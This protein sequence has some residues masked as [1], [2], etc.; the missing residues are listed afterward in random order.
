M[1]AAPRTYPPPPPPPYPPPTPPRASSA[2]SPSRLPGVSAQQVVLGTAVVTVL[3]F[4][5]AAAQ[6]GAWVGLAVAALFA[7]AGGACA[8]LVARSGAATTAEALAVTSVLTTAAGIGLW[9]RGEPTPAPLVAAL[10]ATAALLWTA[11]QVAPDR[12]RTWPVAALVAGQVAVLSWL[13]TDPRPWDTPVSGAVLAVV[14][15]AVAGVGL[16]VAWTADGAGHGLLSRVGLL[17]AVPW[18][19]T[20]VVVAQQAAW[21]G[22]VP[23]AGATVLA[24]AGL[25]VTAADRV[26]AVPTGDRDVVPVLAGV[27][28]GLGV[29]GAAHATG[30]DAV[31]LSGVAGLLLAALVAVAAARGKDWVPRDAG[32]AAAVVLTVLAVLQDVAAARWGWVALL[33]VFTALAS[34]LLSARRSESRPETIPLTVGS[35]AAALLLALTDAPETGIGAVLVLVAVT[36][37]VQAVV[38]ARR[39]ARSA[40]ERPLDDQGRPDLRAAFSRADG[41]N[42]ADATSRGASDAD[43]RAS[44]PTATSG[45][46]TGVVGVLVAAGGDPAWVTPALLTVLGASLLGYAAATHR[47]AHLGAGLLV[48]AAWSATGQLGWTGLERWT[49]PLALGLLLARGRELQDGPSWP[50]WGPAV[51]VGLLPSLALVL[52]DPAEPRHPVLL[53]AGVAVALLGVAGR[54]R[55]PFQLGTLTVAGAAVAW[56]VDAVPGPGLLAL[57]L[58]GLLLFWLA[59]GADREAGSTLRERVAAFR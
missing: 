58:A 54:L 7:V 26:P 45:A 50:T 10:A 23:A 30:A 35:I 31:S 56:A 3:G 53:V 47:P 46:V 40:D 21:G 1:Q 4:V 24:G 43:R 16:A 25:L 11:L 51:A 36:A 13:T 44:A 6:V 37:V 5:L 48:L 34:G 18:W 28:A 29:A 14:L 12:L 33:L 41:G 15:L 17:T 55:A 32:L 42:R 52:L 57:L 22:A 39:P 59:W 19:V 38:L 2:P 49:V 9:A 20:G 27:T 8:F